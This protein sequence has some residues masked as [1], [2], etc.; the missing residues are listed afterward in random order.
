MWKKR[1]YDQ[2]KHNTVVFRETIFE[3]LH[4]SYQSWR[5]QLS[6][7]IYINLIDLI[8]YNQIQLK[9]IK[10]HIHLRRFDEHLKNARKTTPLS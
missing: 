7:I 6:D 3:K 1:Q 5:K 10:N 2:T 4:A 8:I 9:S